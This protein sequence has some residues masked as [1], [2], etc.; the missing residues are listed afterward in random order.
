LEPCPH[1]ARTFLPDRLAVHLRTCGKGHFAQPKVR[2][3]GGEEQDGEAA[4]SSAGAFPSPTTRGNLGAAARERA[5]EPPKPF[6][7]PP[8]A[9]SPASGPDR[10]GQRR[11]AWR[12]KGSPPRLPSCHLCGRQFGTTS[13]GIHLKAC[14]QRWE[15]EH[16]RA[17][18][19]PAMAMPDGAPAGSRRWEAFN[20]AAYEKF[21]AESLESCPHCARTFLPDRLAVHLRTCGKG[22]FAQPKVRPHGGDGEGQDGDSDAALSPTRGSAFPTVE[23]SVITG[24]LGALARQRSA[25]PTAQRRHQTADASPRPSDSPAL[26]ATIDSE[27]YFE[28]V[29]QARHRP[30]T[31]ADRIA[32]RQSYI[33]GA[34]GNGGGDGSRSTTGA[35]PPRERRRAALRSASPRGRELLRGV[36][37]VAVASAETA[38]GERAAGRPQ[39]ARASGSRE[40]WHNAARAASPSRRRDNLPAPTSLPPPHGGGASSARIAAAGGCRADGGERASFCSSPRASPPPLVA[41]LARQASSLERMLELNELLDAQLITQSE[42]DA[43]RNDILDA[44]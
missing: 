13:L 43:K 41:P 2:P 25:S 22:H 8:A 6:E 36:G 4:A 16:G 30:D 32:Q 31:S 21:N 37:C 38:R 42:Y 15:R 44:V 19:E 3:H 11:D 5:N 10:G 7:P 24:K 35:S 12:V 23:N 39:S 18:P 1:C 29:R 20:E 34:L 27:S 28:A 33:P 17:A 40:R 14:K 9:A 26:S